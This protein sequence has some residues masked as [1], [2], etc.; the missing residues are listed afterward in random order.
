MALVS[1]GRTVGGFELGDGP[2]TALLV[3]GWAG[4]L[5]QFRRIAQRLADGGYRCVVIDLPAHGIESGRSTDAYEISEAVE[6]AGEA[7]GKVDLLVAHS[8]GA[9]ATGLAM[10]RSLRADRLVFLAPGLRPRRALETFARTLKLRPRTA[11]AV[12]QAME[13]RFGVDLWDEVPAAMLNL[14]VPDSTLIVHDEDDVSIPIEDARLLS[15]HWGAELIA[16]KGNGHNGVLR[17]ASVIDHVARIAR[18][19]STSIPDA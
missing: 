18:T 16:T 7:L 3:H 19:H 4:S 2:R 14:T 13:D 8:L 17:A 11:G 6:A 5:W 15:E 9:M 1:A 10:Q 12:E